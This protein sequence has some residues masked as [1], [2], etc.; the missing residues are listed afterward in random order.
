MSALR[1]SNL[2]KSRTMP[3]MDCVHIQAADRATM[4]PLVMH[5]VEL[6]PCIN[7]YHASGFVCALRLVQPRISQWPGYTLALDPSYCSCH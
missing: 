5:A 4:L 1:L 7:V 2:G 6:H 3:A